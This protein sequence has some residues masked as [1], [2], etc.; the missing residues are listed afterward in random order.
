MTMRLASEKKTGK[1]KIES[2]SFAR[3]PT[4]VG[5]QG[6][7]SLLRC[8]WTSP[9]LH[10]GKTERG[11]DHVLYD[12]SAA[13]VHRGRDSFPKRLFCVLLR[14]CLPSSRLSESQRESKEKRAQMIIAKGAQ[15]LRVRQ[16]VI[17]H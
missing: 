1:C 12:A 6:R 4:G 3:G 16:Q 13:R 9:R 8:T 14:I 11:R 17:C 5:E 7:F 15:T 10:D 2:L